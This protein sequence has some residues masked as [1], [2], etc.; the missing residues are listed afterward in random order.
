MFIPDPLLRTLTGDSRDSDP[1]RPNSANDPQ[2]PTRTYLSRVRIGVRE[3]DV[4]F[5][6]SLWVPSNLLFDLINSANLILLGF[7]PG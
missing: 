2:R 6:I 7:T 5:V 4:V 1:T 3:V